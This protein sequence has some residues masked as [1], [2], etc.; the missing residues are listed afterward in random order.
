M[1][2]ENCPFS[3]DP[4][5]RKEA[6]TL[7]SAGYQVAAIC[8]KA[9][10]SQP[11]REC[12]D[13]I[14]V[15]RYRP[16]PA[17]L[18]AF[19]YLFE[20]AYAT[21]AIAF[22]SLIVLMREGFD[23]VHVANPPDTMVV[24][25]SLYRVIGKRIIYDQHDLCP[26]LLQAKF[27][28]LRWMIPLLL[29]LERRSY[30]L[31]DHVIVTNES[32]R[33]IALLRGKIPPSKVTIV[34]NGPEVRNIPPTT[35]DWQVRD[36][37]K[38]IIV[39]T[40]TIGSQDGLD[41]L[42]RIL[43]CLRYDL[44]R[45][46]FYCVVL[47]DG[48]ALEEVRKLARELKVENNLWFVGWIDDKSKYLSYLNTADIC[49]SPDPLTNYNNQSTF[50]KIM[51]YMAAGK[52]IVSFDLAETRYS[53]Q[54]AALYS[55]AHD[56]RQFAGLV[57]E[58]MD[59]PALRRELGQRGEKRLREELAWQYSEPALL[60]AYEACISD[61]GSMSEQQDL[62]VGGNSVQ[63]KQGSEESEEMVGAASIPARTRD[64]AC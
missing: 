8:P 13:G 35:I 49:V 54:D 56:E 47:G 43:H 44:A 51:D 48:D 53:A 59:K 55:C 50:I 60:N 30:R 22:L 62:N 31:A 17:G 45:Q 19:G 38:N 16:T 52:P 39:Y 12:I 14:I 2:V 28:Q 27:P 34:R 57:A 40:G 33:T 42:C 29:W 58:L 24:T 41:S 32:Y 63:N 15:Y 25:A 4:R 64:S 18:R 37:S 3:R 36:K 7:Q 26:E 20:Y 11:W 5:V 10:A 61:A 6:G 1:I 23:I 9:T 46:D 21:L